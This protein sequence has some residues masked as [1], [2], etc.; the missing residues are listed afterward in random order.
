[1]ELVMEAAVMPLSL[2][3]DMIREWVVMMVPEVEDV[4]GTSYGVLPEILAGFPP[5]NVSQMS[6]RS[7]PF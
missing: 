1:M 3:Q 2:V 6:Q 7:T 5:G 4:D